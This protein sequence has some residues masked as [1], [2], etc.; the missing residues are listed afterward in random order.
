MWRKYYIILG[1][2]ANDDYKTFSIMLDHYLIHVS[3]GHVSLVEFNFVGI[4]S[5]LIEILLFYNP[6]QL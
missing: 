6:V 1:D 5:Q 2:E 3:N 4:A